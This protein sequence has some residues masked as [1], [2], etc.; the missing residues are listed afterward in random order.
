MPRV[1][2]FAHLGFGAGGQGA[3]HLLAGFSQPENGYC[4]AMGP[5]SRF[6]VNLPAHGA[7]AIVVLHLAP[8]IHGARAAGLPAKVRLDG[9][10]VFDGRMMHDMAIGLVCTGLRPD[11]RSC[12][13]EVT[14][15]AAIT[16]AQAG[17]ASE[18]R[19]LTF[20]LRQAW[21]FACADA[22][23]WHEERRH[24]RVR[25]R[26]M[27]CDGDAERLTGMAAEALV[28]SFESVGLSCDFGLFQREMG[29]EPV[30]LLRFSGLDTVNLF[31]GLMNGFAGLGEADTIIPYVVESLD[32]YWMSE[33]VYGLR[34]HTFIRPAQAA[35]QQLIARE[36]HRL[37]FLVRKFV[38]DVTNGEK[39]FVMRPPEAVTFCEVIAIWAALNV[40]GDN[41]LLYLTDTIPDRAGE[42]DQLGPRLLRG[43][44]TGTLGDVAPSVQIW[45]SL[46][47]N[48]YFASKNP[49]K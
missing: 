17:L 23:L 34:Y 6:N 29:A 42:V 10:V 14:C 13:I 35:P 47:A 48:A 44:V 39:I 8:F 15:D 21:V 5:A 12:T 9:D 49:V 2:L 33:T 24:D 27:A 26:D 36:T 45:L 4:W 16:P 30:G 31:R 20:M 11:R 40:A 32:E 19:P 37:P 1:E 41:I 38:E 22:P 43:H 46:C 25:P 7:A 18:H 28:T 3:A